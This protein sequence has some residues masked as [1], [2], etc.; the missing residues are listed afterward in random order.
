MALSDSHHQHISDDACGLALYL[1]NETDK[2]TTGFMV[3]WETRLAFSEYAITALVMI[4]VSKSGPSPV[5]DG[6]K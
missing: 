6:V 4:L 2:L 1:V 5:D 3:D